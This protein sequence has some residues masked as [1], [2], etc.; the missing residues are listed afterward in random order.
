MGRTKLDNY[1]SKNLILYRVK[2]NI[3]KDKCYIFFSLLI[4]KWKKMKY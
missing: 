3:G 4:I 2:Y 1:R